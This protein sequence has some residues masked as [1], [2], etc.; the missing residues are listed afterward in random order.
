M[1]SGFSILDWILF[2]LYFIVLIATSIIFSKTKV[3]SSKEYFTGNRAM[4]TLAVAISVLATSL[5]Q[6]PHF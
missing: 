5:N 2:F 1:N 6:Q 4:P 3:K